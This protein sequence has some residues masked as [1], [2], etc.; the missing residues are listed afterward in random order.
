[1][2]K[3]RGMPADWSDSAGWEEYYTARKLR[4]EF[5]QASD[6]PGSIPVSA[7]PQL[8]AD[9]L[10]DGGKN[11]WLPGCGFSPIPKLLSQLGLTVY[12]TDI[13]QTAVQFQSS[14]NND[15]SP[16][17]A[18]IGTD[19]LR[20]GELIAEVQ[21]FH[22]PYHQEYFDLI[23]NIKSFQGFPW[24][25]M[26]R[27]ASV[28]YKALR[29]HRVAYFDTMNVQ[30]EVRERLE[31]SLVEAGFFI[32]FYELTKAYR[33]ELNNTGIPYIF[34]LGLPRI[35]RYGVYAKDEERCRADEQRLLAITKRYEENKQAM[36]EK[37]K[38]RMKERSKQAFI[39]Y[40]TG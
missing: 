1:M 19:V 21:D 23:I 38:E 7:Y 35:P 28:H 18:E 32:P 40:S 13:S 14:I 36:V 39:I 31:A 33:A 27:I 2:G 37:E 8:A 34:I 20:E 15:I 22:Y 26:C 24:E 29:P 9:L 12:A 17:I 16:L 3:I 30:G 10:A 5:Y 11:I 25:S 6:R 4:G